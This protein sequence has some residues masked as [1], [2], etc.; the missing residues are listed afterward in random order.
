MKVLQAKDAD[1]INNTVIENITEKSIALS[2]KAKTYIDIS[3][4]VEAHITEQSTKQTT[5]T[6]LKRVYIAISN[7]K[8]N[9]LGNYHKIKGKY[10]QNYLKQFV[11]KLNRR[12]FKKNLFDS[13]LIAS[14]FNYGYDNGD[15]INL[16][17]IN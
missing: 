6:T 17:P 12:Y 8:R 14:T 4:Y 10:L 1:R 11:Y 9:F 13:L 15:T 5:T 16:N 7:A 3:K 2:D